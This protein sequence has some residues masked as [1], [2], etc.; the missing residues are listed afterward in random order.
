MT[1]SSKRAILNT[2]A[3]RKLELSRKLEEVQQKK[4]LIDLEIKSIE[5]EISRTEELM[6]GVK[7]EPVQL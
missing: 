2:Y 3:Q 6:E 7:L 5:G 1:S 4:L